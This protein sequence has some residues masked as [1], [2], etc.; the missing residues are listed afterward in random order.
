MENCMSDNYTRELEGIISE[1]LLPLLQKSSTE[2]LT[3]ESVIASYRKDKR[4]ALLKKRK[5]DQ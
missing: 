4:A 5:D 2:K 3:L 1:Y